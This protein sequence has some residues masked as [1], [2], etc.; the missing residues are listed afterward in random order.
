M[1]K[2][3]LFL[4]CALATLTA[5]TLLA[6][7]QAGLQGGTVAGTSINKT[8]K[9]AATNIY[10][11]PHVGATQTK[12]PWADNTTWVYW[13]QIHLGATNTWFAENIDDAVYMRIWNGATPAVVLDNAS[14]NT[15]TAGSFTA[16][17]AGWYPV[18]IRM[19]NG[20]LGAG[21][22]AASGWTTTKGFGFKIGGASS[23]NGAD[24]T[25]P[26]DDGLMSL[27][28]YDDG[29]GFDDVLEV[30]GV[31]DEYGSPLPSYGYHY[32]LSSND[33][34][35]CSVE[36]VW[37]NAAVTVAARCAGWKVFSQTNLE[38]DLWI[39]TTNGVGNA[40]TYTHGST[41]GRVA[42]QFE[43]EYKVAFT[44]AVAACTVV[45]SYGWHDQGTLVSA[46]AS[47]A[48]GYSFAG[49][50]GDGVPDALR[51][52]PA[53]QFELTAP[54]AATATYQNVWYVKEG[55]DDGNDGRSWDT[56]FATLQ[57][58][59][60]QAAAQEFI[61]VGSGSYN[62]TSGTEVVRID[63]PVRI[64]AVD[65]PGTTLLDPFHGLAV[66][67]ARRAVTVASGGAGALLAGFTLT[68]GFSSS[69]AFARTLLAD[70]NA[71]VSNCVFR[72]SYSAPW[73]AA[74]V[75]INKGCH[76]YGCRFDGTGDVHSNT[77]GCGA[78]SATG[79]STD[80]ALIDHCTFVNYDMT[81]PNFALVR[82]NSYSTLRNC[83][84]AGNRTGG[85]LAGVAS[86][87][88]G[89]IALSGSLVEIDGCTIANNHTRSSCGGGGLVAATGASSYSVR[90]TVLWGNTSI[91]GIRDDFH[92]TTGVYADHLN[93]FNNSCGT[94]LADGVNGNVAAAPYFI[95]FAGGDYA[96]APM[97]T[98]RDAGAARDWHAGA[99]DFAG[100]PR[101]QGSAVDIG[102]FEADPDPPASLAVAVVFTPAV[103]PLPAVAGEP[104][105]FHAAAAGP[106]L[107]GLAFAW[108]FGH[109]GAT[110]GGA[111]VQ[112][113]FPAA[114]VYTVACTAT[115]TVGSATTNL[116]LTVAPV[117]AYVAPDGS[118]TPPYDTREKATANLDAAVASGAR[119][120]LVADGDYQLPDV[121]SVILARRIRVRSVTGPADASLKAYTSGDSRHFD[122]VH[123]DARLDGLRLI[124]GRTQNY[125]FAAA[126][127]ISDGVVSNCV[128]EEVAAVSRSSFVVVGGTGRLVDSTI[129]GR[130]A[131]IGNRDGHMAALYITGAGLVD[132]CIVSQYQGFPYVLPGANHVH[133]HSAVWMDSATAALRNT[134]VI[135]CTNTY[136]TTA[137]VLTTNCFG[138]GLTLRNGTV[139]NCTF[140]RNVGAVD[141]A[142]L[143]VR[144]PGTAS[145]TTTLPD[146]RIRNCAFYGNL[147]LNGGFN[148]LFEY[149]AA[150]EVSTCCSP[151]LENGID[152]N[153]AAVP[154]FKSGTWMPAAGSP[155]V[156]HAATL[157]WMTPVS[158]DLAGA[159]RI[160]GL[161]PDIG[162]FERN[163]AGGT[164]LL[165]R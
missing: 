71:M 125:G 37:T 17:A 84:I 137:G 73:A 76:L 126:I 149:H 34:V 138:A 62:S 97:S 75:T 112:H 55:G 42:W 47:N 119:E 28:R 90:N 83:L 109:D 35:A 15:P 141:G 92:I 113:A 31:P 146:A 45:A 57:H 85:G 162:A 116:S 67:P 99:L 101:V 77:E 66:H 33:T 81:S 159:P 6:A 72:K 63:K 94:F 51:Q 108:D 130:S 98:C 160:F 148:D 133:A 12:P 14:Y 53:I 16:P 143:A 69:K 79:V 4:V 155:L 61:Y 102:A 18:E 152:G 89:V 30:T 32:G 124:K 49:W 139:E 134:L 129:R 21:P 151:E 118:G 86:T 10:P 60:G 68:N 8:A 38:H 145:R 19:Y 41:A 154:T 23:V 131:D 144:I 7:W 127:E 135:D 111:S 122:V 114:G 56:P 123:P 39:E 20:T 105:T 117:I 52:S 95:D 96:L 24:Y 157:D 106:D 165:L 50:E 121:P 40:F 29:L 128:V 36:A 64:I 43:T 163:I 13:G 65:G 150:G 161:D 80:R 25:Y 3:V 27:F 82:L 78:L 136:T 100:Q 156:G 104:V 132:R 142:A 74:H 22:V 1:K 158:L 103:L 153:I 11:S 9:P 87:P 107:A 70:G 54:V 44:S 110:G 164:Q 59:V 115:A 91:T 147:A 93:R 88:S 46:T 58:A 120:V 26:E 2:A 5:S 140:A 48:P